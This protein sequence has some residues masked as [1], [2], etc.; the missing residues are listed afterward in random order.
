MLMIFVNFVN[1]A[2]VHVFVK[3]FTAK[4]FLYDQFTEHYIACTKIYMEGLGFTKVFLPM[5]QSS[6]KR[7]WYFIHSTVLLLQ[8]CGINNLSV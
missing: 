4:V 5:P 3:Y 2:V 7:Y 6:V 1:I 8:Y